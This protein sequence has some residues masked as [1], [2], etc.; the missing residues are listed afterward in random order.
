MDSLINSASR[1]LNLQTIQALVDPRDINIIASI[2]L[3]RTA[4]VDKDGWHFT[5]NGKYTVKSSYQ[6][7]MVYP[8]KEKPPILVGPQLI[9]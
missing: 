5:K 3:S 1:T 8:D 2:P 7:E 9:H 6:V 4:M